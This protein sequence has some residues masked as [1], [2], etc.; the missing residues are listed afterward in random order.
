MI[1]KNWHPLRVSVFQ[2]TNTSHILK[3]HAPTP[4]RQDDGIKCADDVY[5]AARSLF[6]SCAWETCTLL[7]LVQL[8]LAWF[9]DEPQFAFSIACYENNLQDANTIYIVM[10]NA[11]K[12]SICNKRRRYFRASS[13]I[14]SPFYCRCVCTLWPWHQEQKASCFKQFSSHA[15]ANCG[16]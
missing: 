13:K 11:R 4:R 14:P 1:F 9:F 8:L 6:E 2:F 3:G 5:C 12:A 7:V 16:S 15:K 10:V